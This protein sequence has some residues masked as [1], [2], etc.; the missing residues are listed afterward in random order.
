MVTGGAM[1]QRSVFCLAVL[2]SL[3]CG[4]LGIENVMIQNTLK[5]AAQEIVEQDDGPGAVGAL[6]AIDRAYAQV[7]LKALDGAQAD[8]IKSA[9]V[10]AMADR[11]IDA[12]EADQIASMC[13]EAPVPA[14]QRGDVDAYH[15]SVRDKIQ[16]ER[17]GFGGWDTA[18]MAAVLA[19]DKLE[20][21]IEDPCEI[22]E[23]GDFRC[24]GSTVERY[25]RLFHFDYEDVN[26]ARN[27]ESTELFVGEVSRR[28]GSVVL[29][30]R[31]ATTADSRAVSESL[32]RPEQDF[33]RMDQDALSALLTGAGWTIRECTSDSEGGATEHTCEAEKAAMQA[34]I[35]VTPKEGWKPR[36]DASYGDFIV[37]NTTGRFYVQAYDMGFTETMLSRL[38]DAP[39]WPGHR[40][41]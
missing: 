30:L 28:S 22:D 38:L 29:S 4:G 10:D 24:Y 35:R 2:L 1:I 26:D 21:D 39:T 16:R 41:D 34:L 11:M 15:K 40:Q 20:V 37:Y 25:A 7:L 32:I 27:F 23:L 18:E 12:S 31:H 3:A 13:P 8:A 36:V 9:V 17:R 19:S 6:A 33:S 5:A 14:E